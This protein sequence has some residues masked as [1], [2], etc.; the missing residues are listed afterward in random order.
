MTPEIIRE[1]ARNHPNVWFV[2]TPAGAI[3]SYPLT[4]RDDARI[5]RDDIRRKIPD[6]KI[7]S[8]KINHETL[9]VQR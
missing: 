2:C 1:N 7:M 4:S 8:V 9:K 5:T 6:A 3:L